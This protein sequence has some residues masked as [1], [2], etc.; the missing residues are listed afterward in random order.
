M[1]NQLIFLVEDAPEGDYQARA[2]GADIFTE[3]DTL[4]KL[5]EAVRDALL[6]HYEAADRPAMVRLHYV[7]EEVFVV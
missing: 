4:P 3:A 5:R 7:R 2:L 6:C 1:D